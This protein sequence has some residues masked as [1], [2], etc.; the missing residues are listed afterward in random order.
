MWGEMGN[1]M[2]DDDDPFDLLCAPQ[3]FSP[4]ELAAAYVGYLGTGD[5]D[6]GWANNWALDLCLGGRWLDVWRVLQAITVLPGPIPNKILAVVAAGMLEDLLKN[7]GEEYVDRVE[8]LAR[9]NA[10][11]GRMLTGVWPSSIDSEVWERVVRF[12]RSFPDPLDQPYR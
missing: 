4:V 10:T 11:F 1:D 12:C 8:V 6:L 3:E 7:A 9:D 5:E 2:C